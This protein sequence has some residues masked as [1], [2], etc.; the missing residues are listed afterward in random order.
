MLPKGRGLLKRLLDK[1]IFGLA[2]LLCLQVPLLAD[3]YQQF[4]AGQLDA[5]QWQVDGYEKNAKS[6]GY[7]DAREMIA[8]HEQ[9]AVESVRADAQQKL[10]TLDMFD[11]LKY[12][13]S[14]FAKGNLLEKAYYMFHPDRHAVLEKTLQNFKPGVPLGTEELVFGVVA[15]LIL[16]LLIVLPLWLL[17]RLFFV[18]PRDPYGTFKS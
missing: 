16:N 5:T 6:H 11:N 1:L 3:H 13:L 12:G 18:K 7:A 17:T 2:L 14:V 10:K 8:H 15:A 4:L 9:N